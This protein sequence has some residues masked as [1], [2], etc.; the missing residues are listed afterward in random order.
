MLLV[1]TTQHVIIRD[2]ELKLGMARSRPYSQW[3]Q[4]I[5]SLDDIRSVSLQC[6][7]IPIAT[8]S[9]NDLALDVYHQIQVN[10]ISLG[11]TGFYWVLLGLLGFT[12]FY[13][14]FT[15]FYLVLLRYTRLYLILLDST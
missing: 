4:Q 15:G 7:T 1:D 2:E 3:L 12:G 13:W 10:W 8:V 14:V 5:I 9:S 6:W 11:S